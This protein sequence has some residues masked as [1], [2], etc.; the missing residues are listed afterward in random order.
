MRRC[1]ATLCIAATTLFAAAQ[2]T[3]DAAG[4]ADTGPVKAGD[5][6]LES[7]I[8]KASYAIGT[9]IGKNFKRAGIELNLEALTQGFK[10]AHAGTQLA[11]TDEQMQ[12]VMMEFQQ[13]MMAK[14]QE[15]QARE[16]ESSQAEGAEFLEAKAQETGVKKTESGLLYEVIEE[17][18]GE[19]PDPTDRVSVHY[20]GTLIDGKKFDSSHDR[21]QPAE[22]P[23]NG[24]IKGWQE[25]LGMMKEGA[26]WKLYIPGDLG[27]GPRGN[28]QAGIPG[29]A[30][31]VFDVQL[32][33]IQ[34]AP[35]NQISIP[36]NNPQAQ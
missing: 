11:M 21:G 19:S 27:Y 29:N 10:D 31:L 7:N 13:T 28:P 1:I 34:D 22:F 32:L 33:D 30:V 4:S 5:L 23:V 15:A 20:T 9:D 18:T 24:V 35:A 12:S 16:A 36:Q 3:P 25:A 2:D 14:M 17:G 6:T 8:D 26:H